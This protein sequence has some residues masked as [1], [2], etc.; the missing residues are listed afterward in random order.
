MLTA[1]RDETAHRREVTALDIGAEELAALREAEG[2]DGGGGGENGVR[3]EVGADF[4]ELGCYVAEEGRAL[5]GG[6][7]GAEVDVVYEGAGVDGGG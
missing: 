2:V 3:G 1:E 5:I 4:F 6:G 7:A